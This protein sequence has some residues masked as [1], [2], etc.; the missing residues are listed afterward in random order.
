M[1]LRNGKFY[2]AV[3][4]SLSMAGA[5]VFSGCG[6]AKS[7]SKNTNEAAEVKP[8]EVATAKVESRDVPL[9]LQVTGNFAAD[10]LSDV[11]P[12]TSGQ[13]VATPVDVGSFVKQGA[14]IARLDD[15]DAR[16]R[17][18]QS[19]AAQRQ[20]EAAL[21]QAEAKI[22]LDAGGNFNASSV[23]EVIAARQNYE[24]AEAQAKLA[25]TNARRYENLVKT[26]DV[27]QSVADQYRTQAET[28]R[29]QANAARQQLEVALNVARQNNQGIATAQAALDTARAQAAI[30][31]KAVSDTV[32]TAPFSGYI[33]DRPTAVG[34]YVTTQSKIATLIKSD[35]L[36][37][38]LQLPESSAAIA[39]PG[40][41][42][43][44]TVAAFPKA[45]FEGKLNVINPALDAASRTVIAE[46]LIKNDGNRLKPGMF[47]SA[48][49]YQQG[50][51]Q[52]LFI[53]RSA[54]LSEASVAS[55]RVYVVE[56]D[57][58]RVRVV[59]VGEQEGELI[60]VLNGL[61]AT[62]V[63]VTNNLEQLYDGAKIIKK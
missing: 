33:S 53:P 23:P 43:I 35:V 16:L 48:K 1:F 52:G 32:I 41:S 37:L 7:A 25:E 24:A 42:V 14:V 47:A 5:V 15:R 19:L 18:Q 30:A 4:I 6:R 55:A 2:L 39:R 58:A 45:E 11:A 49:I 20:A 44:A 40:V 36:K 9:F 34:E 21:K 3:V 29:A 60:R 26:G 63:V 28:A 50:G 22:G 62:D 51:G 57:V 17:L 61:T 46:A 31:R 27:A 12:Q 10:E 13:V 8:A 38:N 59:Q 54:V 56:G